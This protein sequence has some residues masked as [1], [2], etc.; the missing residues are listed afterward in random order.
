MRTTALLLALL[1]VLAA[2]TG[3]DAETAE[4][5]TETPATE[6]SEAVADDVTETPATETPATGSTTESATPPAEEGSESVAEGTP[7]DRQ[8]LLDA[9]QAS[10]EADTVTS[11][12]VQE[13]QGQTFTTTGT[14]TTTPPLRGNATATLPGADGT[15]QSFDMVLDDTVI[16][17]RFPSEVLP[18]PTEW[19]SVDTEATPI[20][21]FE[22][23][24]QGADDPAVQF[25]FLSAAEDV[26]EVGT[27]QVAGVDTTHYRYTV[28]FSSGLESLEGEAREALEQLQAQL[29]DD[30][31][32][33]EVWI[34]GDDR[35]RQQRQ[36]VEV[37]GAGEV[38]TTITF[39]DYDAPLDVQVPA[40]DQVTPLEEVVQGLGGGPAPAGSPEPAATE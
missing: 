28:D 36:T 25:A 13:V 37:Q 38:V 26:R 19:V 22:A 40:A 20:P 8:V 2:C 3:D 29:G 34:D 15:E 4:D 24:Q 30:T 14:F 35:V 1:V 33:A 17:Y 23:L 21:G 12:S 9:A 32:T 18:A 5:V 31:I 11:T 10:L 39:D 7:A 6:A 16:Y 27:E